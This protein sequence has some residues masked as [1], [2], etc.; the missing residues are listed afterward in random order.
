MFNQKKAPIQVGDV[1]IVGSRITQDGKTKFLP[2]ETF[3]EKITIESIIEDC[4]GPTSVNLNW[5]SLGKSKV[6]M[7]DQNKTW[8]KLS[9]YN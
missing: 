2:I 8:V 6:Y 5:G 3:G 9:N 7:H 4:P 1:V